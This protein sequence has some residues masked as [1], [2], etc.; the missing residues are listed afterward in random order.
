M[1]DKT[2]TGILALLLG[3]IGIH[4]FY[5]GKIGKGFLY[6]FFS[7]TFIPLIVSV[8]EGIRTLQMSDDDFDKEYNPNVFRERNEKLKSQEKEI[9]QQKTAELKKELEKTDK[10]MFELIDANKKRLKEEFENGKITKEIFNEEYKIWLNREK[11]M[12]NDN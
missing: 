5:L 1:K 8:I 3:G 4:K 12:Y 6:F 2:T 11:E 9:K 7:W 10:E